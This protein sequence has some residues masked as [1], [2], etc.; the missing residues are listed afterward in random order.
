MPVSDDGL[1]L[2]DLMIEVRQDIRNID[3]K[4][5]QK[6]DRSRVHELISEVAAQRL[7]AITDKS[8]VAADLAFIREKIEDLPDHEIRLRVLERFRYAVPSTALL[9]LAVAVATAAVQFTH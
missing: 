1:S 3:V 7:T 5:E 9:G 8:L 4:L 6:A 2:R